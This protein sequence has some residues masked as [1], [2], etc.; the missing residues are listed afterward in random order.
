VIVPSVNID[1]NP[2]FLED[3]IDIKI[4]GLGR[5]SL[6]VIGFKTVAFVLDKNIRTIIFKD[7]DS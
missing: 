3:T 5:V 4:E 6:L 7:R 1:L 2:I